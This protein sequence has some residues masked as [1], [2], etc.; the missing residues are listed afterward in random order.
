MTDI[1]ERKEA[2]EAL[3]R[4]EQEKDAI[5]N[6]MLELVVYQDT[7]HCIVWANRV[8]H[9][10]VG[11]TAEQLLGRH[12]YEIW[13]GRGEPCVGCP[14]A[15]AR[16]TGQPQEGD[17]DGPNGR[18]WF[19][20][21]YP[22]RDAN[23]DITGVVKVVLDITEKKRT[24]EKLREYEA[25][26]THLLDQMPDG[27]ALVSRRRIIRANP[28]MAQLFGSPSPD[29]MQG[30][31]T[32]DLAAPGSKKIMNQRS[33]LRTLGKKGRN[34]FEFQALRKDGSTFL[35]EVTLAVDRSEPHPFVLAFIRDVSERKA[36]EEQRKRLS[37]RI[38]TV[39]ERERA[40]IARE[41]HDELGQALMGIKMDMAWVKTH[42]K[43]ID[44]IVP[45]RLKALEELIDTTL[46]S[47]REMAA[48]LHPSVLDRL[49]L[50]AAIEWYAG[51]FERRTGI[52]CMIEVES[53]D[54]SI[55]SNTAIHIYRIFQEALTNIA[56]HARASRVDIRIAQDQGYVAISVSDNG[57]GI[58]SQKLLGPM[59]LGI[60]GMR[61]RAELIK[62]RLDIRNRRGKG[63]TV[64]L[65]VPASP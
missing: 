28:S 53:W 12:C 33:T 35:A 37:E 23:G 43:D 50:S 31:R 38:I 63:T 16:E 47:V 48:S 27:V 30:L 58:P 49:G 13:H 45:E 61:E 18:S 5:L 39:Q 3:R 6:S 15:K 42:I 25:R 2:E 34:R 64:T 62:G 65:Q 41:L 55:D 60:A 8:A 40:S 57:R 51:E 36:Y 22:V 46:E 11:L 1:T 20:R 19:I 32:S 21:S 24:E 59:S 10:S 52:E 44:T 4:S 17:M 14:V 9:E 56:R 29:T 26:Y 7:N 54:F